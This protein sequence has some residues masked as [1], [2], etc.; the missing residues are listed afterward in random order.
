M[1][2]P[3]EYYDGLKEHLKNGGIE[4][5]YIDSL[6]RWIKAPS[7]K[8]LELGK[9]ENTREKESRLFYKSYY[10]ALKQRQIEL[11]NIG[12]KN[13]GTTK[14]NDPNIDLH[15]ANGGYEIFKHLIETNAANGKKNGILFFIHQMRK[16]KYI[17]TNYE[18]FKTYFNN[19]WAKECGFEL[20]Q[21][22]TEV[23]LSTKYK[24]PYMEAVEKFSRVKHK[25]D[26]K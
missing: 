15:F 7:E 14:S 22:K 8:R 23:Q 2:L 12:A 24:V 20:L 6:M 4:L 19:V 5:E 11:I 13:A 10:K 25:M 1:A 9:N 21:S 16:D 18:S 17:R 3:R 26:C